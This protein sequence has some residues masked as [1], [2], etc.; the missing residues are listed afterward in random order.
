MTHTLDLIMQFSPFQLFFK[1]LIQNIDNTIGF[2]TPVLDSTNIIFLALVFLAWL[3]IWTHT[4]HQDLMGIIN[5]PTSTLLTSSP[6][7]FP[8]LATRPTRETLPMCPKIQ[9]FGYLNSG[10]RKNAYWPSTDFWDHIISATHP[11][12]DTTPNSLK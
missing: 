9:T 10:T 5:L 11:M 8:C 7:L 4:N 6:Y 3:M 1:K 2:L 12:L